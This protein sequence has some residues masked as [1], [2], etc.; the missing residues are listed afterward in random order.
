MYAVAGILAETAEQ[1]PTTMWDEVYRH[2]S[3]VRDRYD[4]AEEYVK[5]ALH[6]AAE[7]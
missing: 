5:F 1:K 6:C 7:N 4:E 3:R 2:A